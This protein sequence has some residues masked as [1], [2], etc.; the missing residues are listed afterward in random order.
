[1]NKAVFDTNV[2][3]S[4][5][6]FGGIPEQLLELAT[7]PGRQFQLY[8]SH[9]I[10]KEIMKVLGSDK[11][12]FAKEEIADAISVIDDAADVVSP[13]IRL[14]IIKH[15]ANNRILECAVKAR[16]DYIVSGDKHLLGLK[17]YK[18]IS[19]ITPAQFLTLLEKER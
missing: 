4:A 9:D 18:S 12:N 5:L 3:I 15:E 7:G 14:N 17:E 1:M 11:F 8:T 2:Y 6:G 10:L 13:T 19:S 16:A